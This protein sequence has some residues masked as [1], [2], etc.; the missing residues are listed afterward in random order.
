MQEGPNGV[1]Q[2]SCSIKALTRWDQEI[3]VK[4]AVRK[5][6]TKKKRS[7]IVVV[8]LNADTPEER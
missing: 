3:I 5:S 2:L 7:P 8:G 1:A 4:R 6:K